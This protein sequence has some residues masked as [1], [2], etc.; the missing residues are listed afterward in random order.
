MQSD[1]NESQDITFNEPMHTYRNKDTNV[2]SNKDHVLADSNN[3]SG[4]VSLKITVNFIVYLLCSQV[5][6]IELKHVNTK[7]YYAMS[8]MLLHKC[9]THIFVLLLIH[10]YIAFNL[11]F[12]M[13]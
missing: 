6:H 5:P 2:K 7:F 4:V 11:N 9:R 10:I 12:A 1:I 3:R 8:L 13:N